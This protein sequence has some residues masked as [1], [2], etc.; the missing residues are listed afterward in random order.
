MRERI[1]GV[2]GVLATEVDGD[3]WRVEA[4]VPA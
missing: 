2:G 1:A 4:R 3:T